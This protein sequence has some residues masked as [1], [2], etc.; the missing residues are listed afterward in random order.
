MRPVTG[1]DV[2]K[3]VEFLSQDNIKPL[4]TVNLERLPW[5]I[6]KMNT[7]EYFGRVYLSE[8]SDNTITGFVFLSWEYAD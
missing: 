8:L 4:H 1:D 7:D 6:D 3:V 2:E 5:M